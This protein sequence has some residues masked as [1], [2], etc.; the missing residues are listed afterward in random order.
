M[1]N[2]GDTGE[3][4]LLT[5]TLLVA[6]AA[7]IGLGVFVYFGWSKLGGLKKEWKRLDQEYSAQTAAIL[8]KRTVEIANKQFKVR[9]EQYAKFIVKEIELT[10][11]VE[12]INERALQV[13]LNLVVWRPIETPRRAVHGPQLNSR[14]Q[15][16]CEARQ[17]NA[18]GQPI[19]D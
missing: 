8:D 10:D 9:M 16:G 4:Q 1:P 11:V 18:F 5:I 19:P 14:V 2:G 13:G 3:R 15:F 12:Q 6:G 7:V 17:P